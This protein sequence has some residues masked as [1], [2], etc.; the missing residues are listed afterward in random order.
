MRHVLSRHP[1]L[2]LNWIT[3]IVANRVL[4]SLDPLRLRGVAAE[5]ASFQGIRGEEL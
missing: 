3:T 4:T 1:F 5:S 2:I